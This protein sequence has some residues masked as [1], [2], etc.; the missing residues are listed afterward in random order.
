MAI[1][2]T[3]TILSSSSSQPISGPQKRCRVQCGNVQLRQRCTAGNPDISIDWLGSLPAQGAQGCLFPQAPRLLL[4]SEGACAI[5][6]VRASTSGCLSSVGSAGSSK[7]QADFSPHGI[8]RN[9][10]T[11]PANPSPLLF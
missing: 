6:A 3:T 8:A 5:Q 4:K 2:V 1:F 7:L 9:G 10:T 11:S